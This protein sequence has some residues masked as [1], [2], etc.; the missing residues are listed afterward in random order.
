MVDKT[1]VHLMLCYTYN[2]VFPGMKKYHGRLSFLPVD[3]C[4]SANS[5]SI[6]QTT[7][8]VTCPDHEEPSEST[9]NNKSGSDSCACRHDT[10]STVT[11]HTPL[12]PPLSEPLPSVGWVTVEDDFIL[13]GAVYQSHLAKD[14]L[15]APEARLSDGV[16]HLVFTRGTISRRQMIQ[17]FASLEDGLKVQNSSTETFKVRAFRLEPLTLNGMMTVD[18]E[19]VDYGAIQAEVLPSVARVMSMRKSS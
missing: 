18:G 16:I 4:P 10:H 15:M 7:T 11:T 17:M 8:L 13:V 1:V 9:P 6:N 5:S 2:N 3:N 19:K 12:L 14:N